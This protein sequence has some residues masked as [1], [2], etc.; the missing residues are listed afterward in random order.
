[1]L[2][3]MMHIQTNCIGLPTDTGNQEMISQLNESYANV[4][5]LISIIVLGNKE[6]V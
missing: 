3:I 6:I 2:K 4:Q 1:M 5:E